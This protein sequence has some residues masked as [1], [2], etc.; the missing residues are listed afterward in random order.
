[1]FYLGVDGGGT[2][3]AI[4]VIN[5]KGNILSY[6]ETQGCNYL[7][8]GFKHYKQTLEEGILTACNEAGLQIKD[9]EYSFL[10]I[11]SYGET[12]KA[13]PML[14]Q[15]VEDVLGSKKFKCGNDVEAG[16]AGSLACQPGINLVAGTGAIGFGRD[17]QGNTARC[18]GWG[19]FC[20]DE[21]S[22]YW[23][24]KKV[25]ELFAKE[26][27]GRLE[28]SPIHEIVKKELC[29]DRDFDLIHILHNVY[30]LKRDKVAR[31]QLL[32]FEA[33]KAGDKNAIETY[34][35]AA[36]EYSLTVDAIIRKL[37]FDRSKKVVVSCSGG[38]FKVGDFI[39][40]PLEEYVCK[41]GVILKEAELEPVT[42]AALYALKLHQG[43][44]S[45]DIV[46]SLK[47]QE[48]L[49]KNKRI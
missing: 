19:Y 22:A 40:K 17:Q 33:A 39:M 42:G 45:N 20:G 41:G 26:S 23:L 13:V 49:I 27:D 5:E 37:N 16:W 14:E 43:D 4:V 3:T 28:K 25:I 36:Y 9:L 24:G 7:Q 38:V 10:G 48:G 21:G 34:R 32:L 8:Y 11:P 12:T 6:V 47:K 29:L 30:N 46:T 35:Q 1:M 15:V 44:M 31:L 18:S 2:K